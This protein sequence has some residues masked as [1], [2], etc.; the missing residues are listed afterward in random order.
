[1]MLNHKHKMEIVDNGQE[2][3][4]NREFEKPSFGKDTRKT[5]NI[6]K[7]FEDFKV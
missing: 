3:K 7:I 4:L 5:N 1:M 2:K 6:E